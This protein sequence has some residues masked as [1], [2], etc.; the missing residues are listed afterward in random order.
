MVGSDYIPFLPLP[1]T[2]TVIVLATLFC[3][4]IIA[5]HNTKLLVSVSE[6]SVCV[7]SKLSIGRQRSCIH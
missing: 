3:V 6:Y 2:Y 7:V 5:M 1:S 4:P